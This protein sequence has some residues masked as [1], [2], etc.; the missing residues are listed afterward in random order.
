MKINCHA[1]QRT[2]KSPPGNFPCIRNYLYYLGPATSLIL[3]GI[4]SSITNLVTACNITSKLTVLRNSIIVK[5]N[6]NNNSKI[7]FKVI[8]VYAVFMP[9]TPYCNFF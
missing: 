5:D 9:E 8:V 3:D 6:A 7:L 1:K 4:L 2:S